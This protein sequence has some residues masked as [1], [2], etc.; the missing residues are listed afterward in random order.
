MCHHEKMRSCDSDCVAVEAGE[1]IIRIPK[2]VY[3]IPGLW[4]RY[5]D[6]LCLQIHN[7]KR[8]FFCSEEKPLKFLIEFSLEQPKGGV[9]FVFPPDNSTD[10]RVSEL[11]VHTL[12]SL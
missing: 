12:S 8:L 4:G 7:L 5:C 2:D 11:C 3:G 1:L 6:D 10:M 9:Q